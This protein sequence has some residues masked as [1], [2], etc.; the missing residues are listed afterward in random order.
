[1]GPNTS[2]TFQR[3]WNGKQ[4]SLTLAAEKLD[5]IDWPAWNGLTRLFV[6]TTGAAS[7]KGGSMTSALKLADED[8]GLWH[9]NETW[10]SADVSLFAGL[11]Q[12][13]V[14]GLSEL[15]ETDS[16]DDWYHYFLV[17]QGTGMCRDVL[18]TQKDILDAL[19]YIEWNGSHIESEGWVCYREWH[20]PDHGWNYNIDAIEYDPN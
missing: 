7:V 1:M 6:S 10:Q 20:G 13:D 15:Y 11:A 12:E 3:W 16:M 17:I 14:I 9:T 18:V 5:A 8:V 2:G 4:H 19:H